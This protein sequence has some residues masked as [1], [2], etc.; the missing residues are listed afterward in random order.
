[1]GEDAVQLLAVNSLAVL[2]RSHRPLLVDKPVE[3]IHVVVH[4]LPL[5][6]SHFYLAMAQPSVH[7]LLIYFPGFGVELSGLVGVA[8][9]EQGRSQYTRIVVYFSNSAYGFIGVILATR[10]GAS[11]KAITAHIYNLAIPGLSHAFGYFFL[12]P[13]II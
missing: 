3:P 10:K 5:A 9:C 11:A 1:M 7:T 12:V 6:V 2:E 8:H 4:V 13:P